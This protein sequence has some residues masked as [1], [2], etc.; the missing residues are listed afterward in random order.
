MTLPLTSCAAFAVVLSFLWLIFLQICAG[1]MVFVT[2]SLMVL[3]TLASMIYL[4]YRYY[5]VR[6]PSFFLFGLCLQ[7]AKQERRGLKLN[8][9]FVNQLHTGNSISF[10]SFLS[11][12]YLSS[13]NSYALS[14]NSYLACGKILLLLTMFSVPSSFLLVPAIIVTVISVILYLALIFLRKRII[15]AVTVIKIASR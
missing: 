10:L 9:F 1:F 6:L 4:W 3:T 15:L 13:L 14:E 5:Q 8:Y 2:V 12:E 7:L 11:T